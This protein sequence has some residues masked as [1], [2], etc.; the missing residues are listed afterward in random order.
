MEKK[1]TSTLW[2]VYLYLILGQYS[3]LDIHLHLLL[4]LCLNNGMLTILKHYFSSSLYL[5]NV[6]LCLKGHQHF[7][8]VISEQ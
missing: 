2:E 4:L 7:L 5:Q 8:A 6:V 1:K 3:H